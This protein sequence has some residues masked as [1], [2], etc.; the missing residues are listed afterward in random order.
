MQ[1]LPRLHE[2]SVSTVRRPGWAA[3]K[4]ERGGAPHPPLLVWG[5]A[6]GRRAGAAA[7]RVLGSRR[8]LVESSWKGEAA[9][10]RSGRWVP[11]SRGRLGRRHPS[12]VR[13]SAPARP[14]RLV[15]PAHP[16]PRSPLF[17]RLLSTT[18]TRMPAAAD[19]SPPGAQRNTS[20]VPGGER[21]SPVLWGRAGPGCGGWTPRYPFPKS[22]RRFSATRSRLVQGKRRSLERPGQ[23]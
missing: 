3:G 9:E 23:V 21:G 13:T 20:S 8:A 19:L 7:L 15:P 4:W 6:R 17:P 2:F 12:P 14:L 1:S 16:A 5:A 22:R 10:P 11:W 18:P